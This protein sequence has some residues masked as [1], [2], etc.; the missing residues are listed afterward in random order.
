MPFNNFQLQIQCV[1]KLC[2]IQWKTSGWVW[3]Q[4]KLSRRYCPG[5]VSV[6]WRRYVGWSTTSCDEIS[7]SMWRSPPAPAHMHTEFDARALEDANG[8]SWEKGDWPLHQHESGGV[9]HSSYSIVGRFSALVYQM[10]WIHTSQATC[11]NFSHPLK[12]GIGSVY[13]YFDPHLS[14]L[15]W[16]EKQWPHDA[17]PGFKAWFSNSKIHLT[18]PKNESKALGCLWRCPR[19]G[20]F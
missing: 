2:Q 17:P 10:A 5:E 3:I 1:F 12:G 18:I 11:N 14:W 6:F 8:Y 13:V 9:P 19:G 7:S 4:A 20:E 16:T 15:S